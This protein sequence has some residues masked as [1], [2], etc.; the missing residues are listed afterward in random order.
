MKKILLTLSILLAIT[1]CN[2]EEVDKK[3]TA[4]AEPT[5]A[6]RNI[7]EK[8]VDEKDSR[9]VREIIEKK[10]QGYLVQDFFDN[11]P[12]TT[13]YILTNQTYLRTPAKAD[14]LGSYYDL[15]GVEGSITLWG[16]NQF[17]PKE[18][19]I[20]AKGQYTAGKREG[21]WTTYYLNG[22]KASESH[23]QKG[24][25]SGLKTTWYEGGQKLTESHYLNGKAD[26]NST[27]WYENGNKLVERNYSVGLADGVYNYWY[28]NGQQQC[29]GQY[30]LGK[31][32]GTWTYWNNKGQQEKQLTYKDDLLINQ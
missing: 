28:E 23:Y 13:P 16:I 25:L 3:A 10:P 29:T 27:S 4:K 21:V 15:V 26:G 32:Q 5:V 31:K 24:E 30:E 20:V 7:L 12:V 22:N 8:V 6:Q 18:S 14:T 1:A 17:R 2:K 9:F 11:F 19:K